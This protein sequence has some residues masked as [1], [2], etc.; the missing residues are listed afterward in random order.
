MHVRIDQA[1]QNMQAARVKNPVRGRVGADTQRD[2]FPRTHSHV[3]GF[4]A[5]CQHAGA[6]AKHKVVMR[7]HG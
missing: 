5:P 1:G 6:V 4:R 3:R 7:R 2:D